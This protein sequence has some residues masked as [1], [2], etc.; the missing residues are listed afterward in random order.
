MHGHDFRGFRFAFLRKSVPASW[1]PFFETGNQERKTT[2]T[3]F[4]WLQHEVSLRI[5]IKPVPRV[6]RLGKNG[7]KS[8][9]KKKKAYLI[10]YNM[11]SFVV[12]VLLL[13]FCLFCLFK[14]F[15]V[16]WGKFRSPCLGKAQQPQEQRY[17]FL[18]VCVVF[19]CVRTMDIL[20]RIVIRPVAGVNGLGENGRSVTGTSSTD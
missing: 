15:F 4:D 14:Y 7:R 20:L 2:T 19:S 11:I 17:P 9:T 12:V 8:R 10:G 5:V 3:V 13:L 16:P 18:S 6:H 1:F